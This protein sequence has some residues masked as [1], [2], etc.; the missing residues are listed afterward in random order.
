TLPLTAGPHRL[1]VAFLHTQRARGVD[2][3]NAVLAGSTNVQSLS[4]TGP[5]RPVGPGDTP[6]RRRVF[7]CR[8]DSATTEEA[9]ARKILGT[10]A[11]RAFRRPV[12]A[13]SL[14]ILM[15]FYRQGRALR[16]FETG[17]QYALARVL[18]DPQF[19]FRFEAEP[20]GLTE[21]EV[22]EISEFELAS[23]LS[24]FIWSSIPDDELLALA[25]AGDLSEPALLAQQV[26]RM[27]AD[28]KASA[29][30]SNFASQWLGLR[31][32]DL[33]NPLS[34]DFDGALKLAMQ[35]ETE[36]LFASILRENRSIV[37]LLDADYSFINERLARHYGIPNIRGSHFR[38]LELSDEKRR[39]L[40]GQGSI[41]TLTSAPNRTSPVKRGQWVM[42][43]LL[44]TP[45]P[46]PPPGVE[47]NLEETA[48]AGAEL[49]T[50]RQRL[51]FHRVNPAC[52]GCHSMMDPIGFALE[53]FDLTGQWRETE[54]GVPINVSAKL[55]DGTLLQGPESLRQ[56]LLE[57]REL[58]VA[59]AAEKLLTY[60]L[61]R[62][63]EYYDRP[64][65]RHIVRQA[66]KD[67]YRLRALIQE[68]VASPAFQMRIKNDRFQELP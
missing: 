59:T 41:L 17:I 12:D 26:E 11:T 8:P 5:L 34:A 35:R 43:N 13:I 36:R 25:G 31:Q 15:D 47:A 33:V 10:L 64:T 55:W 62:K 52:A 66:G 4:I 68:I 16:G 56:A 57:R 61:G 23:R 7:I 58:F 3:L 53:N 51:E 20:P 30:V 18:V 9:C 45:P 22:Y 19:V 44:G 27:L 42:D 28:P 6:S 2:D 29:L 67:D 60:A 63:V 21:G 49:T 24:F 14:Q 46:P 32:L 38:R 48:P 65:L 37:T 50:V 1:E 40:L 54:A 39:G